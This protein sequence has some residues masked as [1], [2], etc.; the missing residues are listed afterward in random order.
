MCSNKSSS[1]AVSSTKAAKCSVNNSNVANHPPF[2]LK[3]S[4]DLQATTKETTKQGAPSPFFFLSFLSFLAQPHQKQFLKRQFKK[5]NMLS[6]E[7]KK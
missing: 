3:H 2:I 6:L 1:V 7:D 5:C 4:L